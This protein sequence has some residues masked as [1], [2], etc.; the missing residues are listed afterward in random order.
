MKCFKLPRPWATNSNEVF[1]ETQKEE[2]K[3]V[4]FKVLNGGKISP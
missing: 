3:F 4:S 2:I 1:R